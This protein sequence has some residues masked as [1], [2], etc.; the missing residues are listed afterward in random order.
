MKL[1]FYLILTVQFLIYKE[2]TLISNS[3]QNHMEN[4]PLNK[5]NV[6]TFELNS[7]IFFFSCDL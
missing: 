1:N 5:N 7:P 6:D 2:K 3:N 4:R